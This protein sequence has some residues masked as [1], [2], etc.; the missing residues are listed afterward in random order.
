MNRKNYTANCTALTEKY[1]KNCLFKNILRKGRGLQFDFDQKGRLWGQ[2]FCHKKYQGYDNRIHGGIMSTIID[3]S[4]VHCLMG[5]GLVGVTVNL[6][7]KYRQP[8]CIGQPAE[9]LTELLRTHFG[10]KMAELKTEIIQDKITAIT[11][12][13]SFYIVHSL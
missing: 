7:V 2:F 10:G 8:V 1:H 9:F 5:H 6:S 4:M 12:R 11:A 13:S 3:E